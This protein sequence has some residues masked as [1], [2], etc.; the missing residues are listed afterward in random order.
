VTYNRVA[1]SGEGLTGHRMK[2]QRRMSRELLK[3]RTTKARH[4]DC[5]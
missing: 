1:E 4:T 5:Y 3:K 2:A